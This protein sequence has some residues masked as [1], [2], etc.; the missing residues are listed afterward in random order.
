M[1]NAGNKAEC[2]AAWQDVGVQKPECEFNNF[3]KNPTYSRLQALQMIEL[4][5]GASFL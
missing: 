4:S 3:K 5:I 2:V 1:L